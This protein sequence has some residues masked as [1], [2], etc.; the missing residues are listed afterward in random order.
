VSDPAA[1]SRLPPDAR[2]LLTLS[3]VLIGLYVVLDIVAQLLPPHYSPISQAESD[4][5]VGPYGFVMTANFVV[6][7]VLSLAFLAGLYQ[8]T[9]VGRRSPVGT[10]LVAV[11]AVGAF[12]LAA[13]PTDVGSGPATLHGMV[14]DVMAVLVFV[15]AAFGEVLLS[16]R[17]AGDPRLAR[18][19]TPAIVVSGMAL[20]ALLAFFYVAVHP[21]LMADVFGL[22]ERVFLGLVLLWMLLVALYLLRR[23]APG[24]VP[25]V[26]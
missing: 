22:V 18:F 21:R 20:L 9:T 8:A 13:S 19:R 6:R 14:H 10:G 24:S 16:V 23:E 17:F 3:V 1:P 26:G 11:W 4:L 12:V 5:A 15:T 25:S 2:R 7:G